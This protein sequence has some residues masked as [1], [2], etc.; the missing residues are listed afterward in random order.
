[1]AVL[2]RYVGGPAYPASPDV[3]LHQ[4]Q[5]LAADGVCVAAV[6]LE[7]HE[8]PE[9]VLTVVDEDVADALHEVTLFVEDGAGDIELKL[10]QQCSKTF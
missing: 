3:G 8:L 6:V 9:G 2:H 7:I 5:R 1:M 4:E 10:R